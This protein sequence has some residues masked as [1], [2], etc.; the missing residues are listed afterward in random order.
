MATHIETH[1]NSVMNGHLN[2]L[3]LMNLASRHYLMHILA[4]MWSMI[5]SV[6]LL[7]FYVFGYG[8][9]S[10]MLVIAGTFIT[11][12]IFRNAEARGRQKSPVLYLS[13]ASKCVWKMDSEA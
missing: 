11:I 8:W 12:A 3:K 4:W 10:H 1:W 5:F 2:P 7:S 6:S 9:L 13:H